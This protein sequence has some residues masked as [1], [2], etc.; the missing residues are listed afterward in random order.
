MANA[1][2][3]QQGERRSPATEIVAGQ[4]LSPRTEFKAGQTAHNRLEVGAVT[5]RQPT[6]IDRNQRA[7]VK[8]AEPNKWKKRAVVVWEKAN[9]AVPRGWVVHHRDRNALN[10]DIGNLQAMSRGDHAAEHADEMQDARIG[11]HC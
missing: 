10:D 11:G 1:G 7:W 5:I 6:S 8:V 2:Q 3:I 4:R 9:G